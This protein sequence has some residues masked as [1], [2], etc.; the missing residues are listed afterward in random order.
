MDSK[1]KYC[2]INANT[3]DSWY[4]SGS[5]RLKRSL[6][7]HGFSGDILIWNCFPNDEFN[8]SM[9]YNVK[10]SAFSEAIKLG[11]THILWLDSSAWAIQN[12]D[13]IFDII[14][15]QGYYFWS[16]GYNCAQTCSDNCLKYFSI[17]RD[18]A[19]LFPDCGTGMIGINIENPYAKEFITQWLKSAKEGVFAGSRLH[20][21]QSCDPRFLFHRQDQSCASIIINKLNLKITSPNIYLSYYTPNQNESTLF[22]LKGM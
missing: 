2:I 16:S 15:E 20:D 17:T 14:N 3:G 4:P 10:A 6:I 9:P 13:K 21:N 11:Y 7:Y 1:V 5:E 19:E 18:Q 12:P 22:T 8:K